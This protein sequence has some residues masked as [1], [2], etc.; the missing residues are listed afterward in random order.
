MNFLNLINKCLLELNFRQISKF[1]ELVKNDHKR[2]VSILNVINNEVCNSEKWNFLLRNTTLTLPEKTSEIKNTI[3]GRIWYLIID[4]QKYK[5]TE[6][7]EAFLTGENPTG[8]FS[9]CADKILLPQFPEKKEVKILYYS[10]YGI[11]DENG[12]EKENFENET[13]KSLI[14]MPF[15]EQILVYGTCLRVKANPQHI[16]FAYWMSMYKEAI[17]NLKSKS[18]GYVLSSPSVILHRD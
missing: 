2:I 3:P 4:G 17:L 10:K 5:Y 12:E 7:I 8:V 14:P 1:S 18:S 11:V 15:A 9:I 6:D 13:D 16:K